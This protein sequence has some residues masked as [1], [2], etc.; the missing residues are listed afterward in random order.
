MTEVVIKG[1]SD[2]QKALDTLPAKIEQNVMRGALRAGA[3]LIQGEARQLVPIG[4][5]SARNAAIYGG[6]RGLLQESIRIK[7][8]ARQGT[9]TSKVVAG[10][11]VKGG[12]DAYYGFMVEKTGAKPHIIKARKGGKLSFG[13]G[14]HSSVAHPGFKAHPFMVPAFDSKGHQAVVAASD[15]IRTRL[16]DKHG[17]DVAPPLEEGDE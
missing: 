12:G 17:I 1:L 11:K 9:V 8:R 10:G 6:R 4:A 14:V 16:A 13:G 2:L 3:K 7:T 5:P 15:Y